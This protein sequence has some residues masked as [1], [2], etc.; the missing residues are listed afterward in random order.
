MNLKETVIIPEQAI[1][2]ADIMPHP[3]ELMLMLLNET[4][5][6]QES[7]RM[8]GKYVPQPRLTAW[9]GD[10]DAVYTYSGLTN[11]PLLW[12]ETLLLIRNLAEA[13]SGQSF[14][15]VLLN[16]YRN[17]DDYMGYHSDDESELGENPVIASVSLGATR[18]FLFREQASGRRLSVDLPG[19]SLLLMKGDLQHKWKHSLPKTAR[20]VAPRINLTFR[21]VLA[22]K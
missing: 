5:W 14:N 8:F 1:L 9:Y 11:H 15:S 4:P 18:R 22:I 2:Y 20:Q 6:K 17:G 13:F 21:K 3:E 19:N 10:T 16:L 7:I 12:N